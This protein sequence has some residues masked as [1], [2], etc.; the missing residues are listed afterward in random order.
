M[1]RFSHALAE[2][3]TQYTLVELAE[4]YR[5][6]QVRPTQ[7]LEHYM[8][9]ITQFNGPFR[10]Y[11]IDAIGYNAFS[12]VFGDEPYVQADEADKRFALYDPV[13]DAPPPLLCGVPLG[14]KEIIYVKGWET[15]NGA[16]D[17]FEGN[18]AEYDAT[19]VTALREQGAVLIGHTIASKLSGDADGTFAGNAWD[20]TRSPGGS[21]QGSGVAPMIR[22]CVAAVGAETGGSIIHPG[23]AN[24]ASAIKPSSGLISVA[25]TMPLLSGVDVLGPIARSMQDAAILMN[26]LIGVDPKDSQTQAAPRPPL[27]LP[28]LPRQGEQPLKGIKIGVPQKDWMNRSGWINQEPPYQ[29]YSERYKQAFD[30]LKD[31]L[32]SLGATV[33]EFN[34]LDFSS[35]TDDPYYAE[36]NE[37]LGSVETEIYGELSEF[38]V[39]ALRAVITPYTVESAW[40]DEVEKFADT[41]PGP[42]KDK[43]KN[44]F[45]VFNEQLILDGIIA[46]GYLVEGQRRLEQLRANYVAA[47]FEHGIDFMLVLPLGDHPGYKKLPELLDLPVQRYY[48]E[49]PNIM[50]WP[51][52]TFPIGH[53][54]TEGAAPVEMPISAAF[55]G[56]RFKDA[57]LV[58]AVIDYQEHFDYHKKMPVAKPIIPSS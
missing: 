54:V 33:V 44:Y 3:Y 46:K 57:V 40:L 50:G 22:F 2:D 23:A 41:C 49:R 1:K 48:K 47:L 53:A 26:A 24:G 30:R 42:Q 45:I 52:V 21:S 25:G 12:Q 5:S 27:V 29:S 17:F 19:I 37:L 4:L 6:K 56:P 11:T 8:A 16:P 18:F 38:F 39:S 20:P 10:Q 55:W 58:Q 14:L 28:T 13:N 36:S 35:T 9:R 15:L 51:M 34:G 43:L 32:S 7:V 31:E